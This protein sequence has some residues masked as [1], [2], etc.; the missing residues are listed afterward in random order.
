MSDA[1]L[2]VV[3][4]QADLDRFDLALSDF[5]CWI[6]GFQAAGGDYHPGSDGAL[7]DLRA[8]IGRAVKLEDLTT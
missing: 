5:L 8:A 1:R 3:A 2:C 6:G 7:R 4:T